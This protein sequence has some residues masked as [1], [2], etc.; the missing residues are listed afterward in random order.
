MSMEPIR[1]LGN[2]V[3]VQPVA[4]LEAEGSELHDG[5]VVAVGDGCT[6][7]ANT[8]FSLMRAKVGDWVM[9]YAHAGHELKIEGKRLLLMPE[10]Q[11]VAIR[12]KPPTP[13]TSTRIDSVTR[14]D[15]VK[16]EK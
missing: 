16:E 8:G 10:T 9:F 5:Q 7:P 13:R 12:N 6:P 1:L 3:L 2:N 4:T 11:I 14:V 15:T